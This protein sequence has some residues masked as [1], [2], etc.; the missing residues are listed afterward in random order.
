MPDVKWADTKEFTDNI[1]EKLNI[2]SEFWKAENYFA[3]YRCKEFAISVHL[4]DPDGPTLV[5][6]NSLL[7]KK[8]PEMAL[9]IYGENENKKKQEQEE[10]KKTFKP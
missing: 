2:S 1:S 5:L 7:V 10:K 9:Q 6:E 4:F 8:L 3:F